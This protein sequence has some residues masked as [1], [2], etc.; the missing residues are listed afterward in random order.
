MCVVI[1]FY[2]LDSDFCSGC[3]SGHC[4]KALGDWIC[5]CYLIACDLRDWLK[6]LSYLFRKASRINV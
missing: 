5:K 1:H 2:T 4:V 3:E 6:D